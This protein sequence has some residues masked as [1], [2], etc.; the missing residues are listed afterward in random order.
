MA[1]IAQMATVFVPVSDQERA[2]EFYVGTLGFEKRSDFNYDTGERWMEVVPGGGNA[3][4]VSP[5]RSGRQL[6]PGRPADLTG[7]RPSPGLMAK[8]G[9]LKLAA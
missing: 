2:L 8:P 1:E 3:A 6:V 5:P 9:T 4:H 7:P